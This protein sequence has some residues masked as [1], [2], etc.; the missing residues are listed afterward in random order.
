MMSIVMIVPAERAAAPI[1]MDSFEEEDEETNDNIDDL[2]SYAL[3]ESS[4]SRK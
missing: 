2:S 1:S 3:F 4:S